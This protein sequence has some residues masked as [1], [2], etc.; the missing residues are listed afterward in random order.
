M[1]KNLYT[2]ALLKLIIISMVLFALSSCQQTSKELKHRF[3]EEIAKAKD[4]TV[5]FLDYGMPP[6]PY[7]ENAKEIIGHFFNI[8]YIRV[9]GC[10]VSQHL[11]DSVQNEDKK[12]IEKLKKRTLTLHIDTLNRYIEK[13]YHSLQLIDSVIRTNKVLKHNGYLYY[14][15]AN[16]IYTAYSYV[17]NNKDFNINEMVKVDS[18][19]LKII[20]HRVFKT[21]TLITDLRNLHYENN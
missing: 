21:D 18:A 17:Y 10:E 19:S 2:T 4:T 6:P 11:I 14:T 20:N 8:K 1:N 3:D 5:Y 15:K 7:Y 16:N 13:E 12:A 9:A